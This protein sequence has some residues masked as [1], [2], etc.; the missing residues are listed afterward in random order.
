MK[1]PYDYYQ[2]QVREEFYVPSE[3]KRCWASTLTVLQAVDDICKRHNLEYFAD[4]GTLLGAIRHGGFIPWDDD[5]DISMKRDDYMRFIKYAQDELPKDYLAL[6]FYTNSK[7]DNYLCRVVSRDFICVEEEFL[8]ENHC[9][10]YITGI[11]IFPLDYFEEDEELNELQRILINGAKS[12]AATIDPEDTDINNICES[13]RE[14]ILTMCEA[15]NY[16]LESGKPIVSQMFILSDRLSAIYDSSAEKLSNIYF[17]V[18]NKTHVY[19]KEWFE[20]T[21]RV[22]FEYTTIPVPVGYDKI[23]QSDYGPDYMT[24][25]MSWNYHNYP[26]YRNQKDVL[27]QAKGTP[28]FKE[29]V[30]DENDIRTSKSEIVGDRKE[31]VFLPF[32]PDYW[33]YMEKEWARLIED[34]EWDVYVIPIPYYEKK[35]YGIKGDIFYEIDGYP[36]YVEL[37]GFDKYDFDTRQPDRIYIQNP[38]DDYDNAITVHPR[39][40]TENLRNITSELIYIP[41]FEVMDFRK[42]DE[43][44]NYAASFY[45]KVPGVTRADKIILSSDNLKERYVDLLCEFAGEPTRKIWNEKIVVDKDILPERIIGVFEEDVPKSWWQYLLDSDGEGKKVLLYHTSI[46]ALV[47]YKEMYLE[48]MKRNIELFMSNREKLTILWNVPS[49][50]G[51][52]LETYYPKLW[53]K[54]RETVS[55][56]MNQSVGIYEETDDSLKSCLIADAYYGDRDI[57][58]NV[59]KNLGK[60]VMIQNFDV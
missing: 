11:D 27:T 28:F 52:V 51:T 35:E 17:F 33:R 53:E 60:P 19:P 31:A 50:I 3:M 36:D 23:L 45:V 56:Y 24:P 14:K 34:P 18:E 32:R 58:M 21:I 29:Y 54:Y 40:Y 44:M 1:I 7:Y 26:V 5:F 55:D 47:E 6:S 15:C 12:I 13:H 30:F 8:K 37:V 25:V 39:F 42:E 9:F 4:Y 16:T 49:S 48:K 43:R 38:Y 57:A 22:P 20:R 41:Y 10:P 2:A 59:C 46:S